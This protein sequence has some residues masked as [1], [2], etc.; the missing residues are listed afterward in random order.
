MNR[1]TWRSPSNIALIKY[2]GK[3]A[4][5][6]PSNPSISF[7]LQA[8][9]TETLIEFSGGHQE[10]SPFY[11]RAIEEGRIRNRLVHRARIWCMRCQGK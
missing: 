8:A 9:Y 7:S 5:Q 4:G 2:W 10:K 6:I 1:I 3:T 11:R